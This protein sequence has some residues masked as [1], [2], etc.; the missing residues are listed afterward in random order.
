MNYLYA[1]FFLVLSLSIPI[2]SLCQKSLLDAYIEEALQH[3]LVLKQKNIPL[4]KSRL[5]LREAEKRF[6][7][8]ADFSFSY[9]LALGGRTIDLP[10]GDLLNPV[11]S[12][13]NK[14]TQSS[15]F[16]QLENVE[17]QLLPNDF[18]DGRIRIAYSVYNKDLNLQK[19]I[20]IQEVLLQENEIDIYRR[21]LILAVK[22][23]YYQYGLFLEHQDILGNSKKLL[24]KSLETVRI[25]VREGKSLPAQV[26]RAENEIEILD[27]KLKEAEYQIRNAQLY[28]K[29]LL[30]RE[31]ETPLNFEKPSRETDLLQ[32]FPTYQV[33][34]SYPQIKKWDMALSVQNLLDKRNQ[35]FFMPQISLF[36]DIGSQEF[37]W[38]FNRKSFYLIGGVQITMPLWVNRINQIK[39]EQIQLDK[40]AIQ[41]NKELTE[42]QEQLALDMVQNKVTLSKKA[43]TSMAKQVNTAAVY[44]RLTEKGFREGTVS[45]LELYDAQNQ[46]TNALLQ[47]NMK[48]Y[49][50]LMALSELQ[51][52]I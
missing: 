10:L 14:L 9:T 49:Q 50:Y 30:N 51:K 29:F 20:R 48:Y 24:E 32:D 28:L 17:N 1:L 34:P 45:L 23:A 43:F 41:W 27:T 2:E 42:Q 18:Y 40:K 39:G 12:T 4:L 13:L 19:N 11:Y 26:L 7:P 3:N 8:T 25:L 5:A 37:R 38:Q 16:P 47:E 15:Q 52:W 44:L 35:Q 6:K 21:E 36:S 46:Y 31:N 33:A 22:M